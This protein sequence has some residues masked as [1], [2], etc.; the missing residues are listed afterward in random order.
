MTGEMDKLIDIFIETTRPDIAL[1]TRAMQSGDLS[2][3]SRIAHKVKAGAGSL[4]ANGLARMLSALEREAAS[5]NLE[6]SI[7]LAGRVPPEFEAVCAAFLDER[8]ARTEGGTK[9]S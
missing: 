5:A 4:Y 7:G 2:T 8:A 1:L 9:K 3:V 6:T